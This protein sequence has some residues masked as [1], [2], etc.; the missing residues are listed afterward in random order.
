VAQASAPDGGFS[1]P[2][3]VWVAGAVLVALAISRFS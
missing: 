2:T 3:W 1:L